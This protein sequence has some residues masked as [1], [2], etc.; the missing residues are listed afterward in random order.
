MADEPTE[1]DEPHRTPPSPA[2]PQDPT[3][4]AGDFSFR[5]YLEEL[6]RLGRPLA[7]SNSPLQDLLRYAGRRLPEE[8]RH[9]L[10]S[11]AGGSVLKG[12]ILDEL[13]KEGELPAATL[14]VILSTQV[15]RQS[16][17]PAAD[18]ARALEGVRAARRIVEDQREV[19]ATLTSEPA[20]H[21][22]EPVP[23]YRVVEEHLALVEGTVREAERVLEE[24][25][26][27]WDWEAAILRS[28]S[29]GRPSRAGPIFRPLVEAI[30][31]A[32]KATKNTPEAREAVAHEL[33]PFFSSE[34]L[35]TSK[36]SAL[37]DAVDK[38]LMTR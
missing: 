14:K 29:S 8:I 17:R 26:Y 25:E 35:K 27:R 36:G 33:A 6:E 1:Q 23:S 28:T 15:L 19:V 31:W 2:G 5:P 34:L 10:V 18:W 37:Y 20:D 32:Q 21:T 3:G 11:L 30:L 24:N 16:G 7:L 13:I 12:S 9:R 38:A 22:T 4:E